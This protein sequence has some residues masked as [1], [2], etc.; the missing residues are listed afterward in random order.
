MPR[1]IK[2]PAL[3]API[4]RIDLIA[5]KIVFRARSR[6][7]FWARTRRLAISYKYIASRSGYPGASPSLLLNGENT[8]LFNAVPRQHPA[9]PPWGERQELLYAAISKSTAVLHDPIDRIEVTPDKILF[10]AGDKELAISYQYVEKARGDR[11]VRGFM[12]DGEDYWECFGD[13][14]GLRTRDVRYRPLNVLIKLAL[15]M[16]AWLAAI[17]SSLR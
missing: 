13:L 7:L 3:G 4:D 10:R 12:L 2:P 1:S 16:P 8:Y 9:L 11:T 6:F 15:R 14:T 5:K 17:W